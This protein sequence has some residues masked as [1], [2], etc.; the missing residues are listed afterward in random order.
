[1]D[2]FYNIKYMSF[3][4]DILILILKIVDYNFNFLFGF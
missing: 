2:F 1:M 3:I 4:F